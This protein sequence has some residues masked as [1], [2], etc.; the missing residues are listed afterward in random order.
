MPIVDVVVHGARAPAGPDADG[1]QG[2]LGQCA[3]LLVDV[4]G[5]HPGAWVVIVLVVGLDAA[6]FLLG[7]LVAPTL[8]RC[9]Q[10]CRAGPARNNYVKPAFNGTWTAR[11]GCRRRPT[12]RHF[13]LLSALLRVDSAGPTGCRSGTAVAVDDPSTRTATIAR[14]A[15]ERFSA[16][17]PNFPWWWGSLFC[18]PRG[19]AESPMMV[20]SRSAIARCAT[21]SSA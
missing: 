21:P 9:M 12:R 11:R 1:A 4:C 13:L 15:G 16:F 2:A 7:K 3:V 20:S 14:V 19:G 8:Q 6:K 5:E 10:R 17:C 18:S